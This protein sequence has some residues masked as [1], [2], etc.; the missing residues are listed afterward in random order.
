[1]IFITC[2]AIFILKIK[3]P[4]DKENQLSSDE[5]LYLS[6]LAFLPLK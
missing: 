4:K 2:S 3:K 6:L 5:G 1:M